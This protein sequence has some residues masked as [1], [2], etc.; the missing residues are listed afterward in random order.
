M[1][2]NNYYQQ[3][4]PQ[5][6]QYSYQNQP[7]VQRQNDS[8]FNDVK[9]VTS[10]EAKAFIVM[11]NT[12]VMLMDRDKSVFYIKSADALG[13]STLEGF[14]YSKLEDNEPSEYV[15]LEDLK[16]FVKVDDL[17]NFLTKEDISGLIDKIDNLQKQVRINAILRGD[18][19]D[20]K[21]QTNSIS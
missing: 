10:D 16:G 1:F 13:K 4:Y 21:Q 2:N 12:K 20:G 3:G 17:A 14:R 5:Y 18:S 15:K 7:M 19:T 11:P 6:P 8:A 9:F